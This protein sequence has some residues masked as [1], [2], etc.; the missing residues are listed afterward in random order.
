MMYPYMTLSDNTEITHSEM[1][2]DDTVKVYIEKP[3]KKDGFHYATCYL[4]DYRWENIFGFSEVEMEYYKKLI[5]NNAHL[6]MDF[7]RQGGILNA[8]NF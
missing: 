2:N 6:I 4:P 5:E 8:S 7:S 3:D 1:L